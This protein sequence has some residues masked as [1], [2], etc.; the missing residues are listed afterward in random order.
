MLFVY[1]S[2]ERTGRCIGPGGGA[3]PAGTVRP[4]VA[5]AHSGED[6]AARPSNTYFVVFHTRNRIKCVVH[7]WAA[8]VRLGFVIGRIAGIQVPTRWRLRDIPPRLPAAG[9]GQRRHRPPRACLHHHRAHLERTSPEERRLRQ[10][11]AQA[12]TLWGHLRPEPEVP[13]V[14]SKY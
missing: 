7:P 5:R 14:P 12:S 3:S 4:A 6:D 11:V 10:E 9:S 13:R 2:S 8:P 1:F